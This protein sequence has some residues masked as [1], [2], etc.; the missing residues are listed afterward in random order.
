M[1]AP[2]AAGTS[3]SPSPQ[4]SVPHLPYLIHQEEDSAED[5]AALSISDQR[6]LYLV[7]IFI[8]NT[9]KFLNSFASVCEK[10]LLALHRRIVRMD[11][12]L[13]VL[14]A[15][16]RGAQSGNVNTP[17]SPSSSSPI[18]LPRPSRD[19]DPSPSGSA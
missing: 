2:A 14:E 6:T 18:T 9:S 5:E 7:N 13:M 16:L 1:A 19:V 12:M 17:L 8:G 10:K 15:K 3:N 4:I 11:A